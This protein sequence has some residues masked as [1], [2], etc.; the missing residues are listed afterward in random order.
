MLD[1]LYLFMKKY[2]SDKDINKL[3]SR[4]CKIGWRFNNRKKHGA[5][6]TPNGKKITVPSSPSDRRAFKNF[7]NDIRT[8][9]C[10]ERNYV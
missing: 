6:I 3:V 5:L 7:S 2:S 9:I 4:M 8:S 10:R 1:A